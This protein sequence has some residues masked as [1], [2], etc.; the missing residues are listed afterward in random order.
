MRPPWV[1]AG[2]TPEPVKYVTEA[3]MKRKQFAFDPLLGRYRDESTVGVRASTGTTRGP[4]NLASPVCDSDSA[5]G[6]QPEC[7]LLSA[8]NVPV[9]YLL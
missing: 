3:E 5:S 1:A 9:P 6:W 8:S 2:L 4:V 7:V